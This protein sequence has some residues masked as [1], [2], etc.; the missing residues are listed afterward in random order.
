MNRHTYRHVLG[1]FATGVVIVTAATAPGPV[2]LS[3]NS[4]T[5]VSLEPPLVGF[6][7]A[8]TSRSWPS[9][10]QVGAFC[11]NVLAVDQEALARRFAGAV[12][13]RFAGVGWRPSPVSGAPVLDGVI[14]W[15]DC[16][17][18]SVHPA[19]DHVFVTGRVSASGLGADNDPLVFA[20]GRYR[21]LAPPTG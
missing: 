12:A 17:L 5:A 2:G 19:G 8:V 18:E 14:A 3:I 15:I 6:F 10:E 20:H 9:I 11:V 13:D 4:F 7:P 16:M 21:R 1:H